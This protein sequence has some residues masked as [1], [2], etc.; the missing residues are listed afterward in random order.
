MLV[1]QCRSH[2]SCSHLSTCFLFIIGP[3]MLPRDSSIE[4][5]RP[6]IWKKYR[7]FKGSVF[8]KVIFRK[9]TCWLF[10]RRFVSEHLNMLVDLVDVY[11]Y[12][13]VCHPLVGCDI[14]TPAPYHAQHH[15]SLPVQPSIHN[16]SHWGLRNAWDRVDA[17]HPPICSAFLVFFPTGM[18]PWTM[19]SRDT[20]CWLRT[21]FYR[22]CCYANII[23]VPNSVGFERKRKRSQSLWLQKIEAV[24]GPKT[25]IIFF[26]K[27]KDYERQSL[28]I[29]AR[30]VMLTM[31]EIVDLKIWVGE[32]GRMELNYDHFERCP[33]ASCRSLWG[34]LLWM[35]ICIMMMMMMMMMMKT[36]IIVITA[37]IIICSS[38]LNI[39]TSTHTKK[40]SLFSLAAKKVTFATAC[41]PTPC[42]SGVGTCV[43]RISSCAPTSWH[44][45]L[46]RKSGWRY[47]VPFVFGEMMVW[48][49][50]NLV[51]HDSK[52]VNH[53]LSK[54]KYA[55]V[56]CMSWIFAD[57]WGPFVGVWGPKSVHLCWKMLELEHLWKPFTVG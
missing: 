20:I 38:R 4:S 26:G 50:L 54:G 49:E 7:D 51:L 43:C 23:V 9:V 33:Y 57:W 31:S 25:Q 22:L 47:P 37:I 36:I 15:T 19:F 29:W 40:I 41:A 46:G 42:P 13:T 18:I 56:C 16:C 14:L 3:T 34:L 11:T 2:T 48:K 17:D 44:E 12:I 6:W 21:Y 27:W 10:L 55:S 8:C 53:R 45:S 39:S 30:R 32:S 52:K 28:R 1:Y 35:C 24:L 5:W